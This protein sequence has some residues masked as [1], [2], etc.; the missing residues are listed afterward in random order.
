ML[1]NQQA[2]PADHNAGKMPTFLAVKFWGA[3]FDSANG[4]PY[5][6]LAHNERSYLTRPAKLFIAIAGV[7]FFAVLL[8]FI[9]LRL[10]EPRLRTEIIR[11]I[12]LKFDAKAELETLEIS[13]FPQASITGRNLSYGTKGVEIS[14]HSLKLKNF[15]RLLS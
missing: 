1:I 4:K 14:R 8:G 5:I 7:G 3:I 12:E 2:Q 11:A 6:L 9:G 15:L 10:F 13:L